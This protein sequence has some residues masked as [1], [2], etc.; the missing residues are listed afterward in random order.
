MPSWVLQG[1]VQ[2]PAG[3]VVCPVFAS[4]SPAHYPSFSRLSQMA[5]DTFGGLIESW[6]V[7]HPRYL[8][9]AGKY[10]EQQETHALLGQGLEPMHG[11][12]EHLQWHGIAYLWIPTLGV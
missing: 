6:L 9:V 10:A 7:L 12:A 8:C 3:A 5:L 4:S 2:L 1:S 11:T